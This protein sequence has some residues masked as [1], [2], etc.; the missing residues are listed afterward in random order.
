M[1][2]ALPYF[3][4]NARDLE[5]IGLVLGVIFWFQML[6]R[7]ALYEQSSPA[8]F[9]WMVFIIAV[10]GIGSLAYYLLRVVKIRG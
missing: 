4:E 3:L 5:I 1:L 2:F 8:R 7:C 6:R 9:L 10:P